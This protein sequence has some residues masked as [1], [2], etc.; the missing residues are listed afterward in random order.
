MQQRKS[1]L[2]S[3]SSDHQ[4]KTVLPMR[5]TRTRAEKTKDDAED[6]Q[7]SVP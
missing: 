6:S 1:S 4:A 7:I 2:A 3:S 5:L